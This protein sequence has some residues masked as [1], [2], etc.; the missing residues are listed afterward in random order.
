V[1]RKK[2][3]YYIF[4]LVLVFGIV[5]TVKN[6]E[7]LFPA[8]VER[9]NQK[10]TLCLAIP[11][12]IDNDRVRNLFL[13]KSFVVNFKGYE[14][15]EELGKLLIE[16][17]CEVYLFPSDYLSYFSDLGRLVK[18]NSNE[19]DTS[20]VAPDFLGLKF[21]R[22]NQFFFP[23]A[24]WQESLNEQK[25]ALHI[26]LAAATVFTKNVQVVKSVFEDFYSN[27]FQTAI[28]SEKIGTVLRDSEI[29]LP[30]KSSHVRKLNL[31]DLKIVKEEK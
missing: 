20:R 10:E 11:K 6:S 27:D 15:S 5:W 22:L 31:Q 26:V 18:F 13:N 28:A 16:S 1:F 21:D 8:L 3:F 17:E 7:N 2:F 24:Y 4:S 23:V 30:L 14:N 25:S 9:M 12:S 19:I 29:D